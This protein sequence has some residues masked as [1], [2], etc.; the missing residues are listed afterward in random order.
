M[1]VL[2]ASS[3]PPSHCQRAGSLASSASPA[4]RFRRSHSALVYGGSSGLQPHGRHSAPARQLAGP[5]SCRHPLRRHSPR[6]LWPSTIRMLPLASSPARWHAPSCR[7]LLRRHSLAS[8]GPRP[9]GR[10]LRQLNSWRALS[11][12][13]APRRH[14]SPRVPDRTPL[15]TSGPAHWL[16]C[17]ST[18]IAFR[19]ARAARSTVCPHTRAT[20]RVHW[21]Q[22]IRALPCPLV[23]NHTRIAASTGI[24][25]HARYRVHW[26]QTIPALCR[27]P[28][29]LTIRATVSTGT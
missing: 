5:L 14:S 19:S 11:C 29:Y 27:V 9:L 7:R 20:V 10:P 1:A 24:K 6:V 17:A 8:S 12:Q 18:C 23:S 25:P 26:Y 22:T 28:W 2:A 4:P 15:L 21:Y 3:R 16:S 13:R